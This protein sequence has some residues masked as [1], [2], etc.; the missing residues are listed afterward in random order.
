[1][2]YPAVPGAHTDPQAVPGAQSDPPAA[3]VSG[4]DN[5]STAVPIGGTNAELLSDT[6]RE[7]AH[8]S[9]AESARNPDL[10]SADV[11]DGKPLC[12]TAF[13]LCEEVCR[14]HMDH[15]I[16]FVGMELAYDWKMILWAT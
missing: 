12:Y 7:Q 1:V 15:N 10:A 14:F 5:S 4:H 9:K 11:T 16:C 3:H 6:A 13:T 2:Q 8:S